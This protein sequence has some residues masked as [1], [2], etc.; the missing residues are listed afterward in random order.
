MLL[1]LTMNYDTG[2]IQGY[3]ISLKL[4]YNMTRYGMADKTLI[5]SQKPPHIM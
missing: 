3:Y 4:G 2:T 5:S 1:W